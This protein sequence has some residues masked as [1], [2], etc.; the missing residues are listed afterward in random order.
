M[1]LLY[2]GPCLVHRNV[3]KV[4]SRLVESYVDVLVGSMSRITTYQFIFTASRR[5]TLMKFGPYSFPICERLKLH[6]AH[7]ARW[8][9]RHS[10]PS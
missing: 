1:R 7:R 3:R 2:V 9:A 8:I 6:D 5:P 10:H 4:V